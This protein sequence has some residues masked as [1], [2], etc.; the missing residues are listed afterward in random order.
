MTETSRDSTLTLWVQHTMALNDTLTGGRLFFF[1]FFDKIACTLTYCGHLELTAS[2]TLVELLT[3]LRDR[4]DLP[5]NEQ[6]TFYHETIVGGR[7]KVMEI[8][9]NLLLAGVSKLAT[10]SQGEVIF[11]QVSYFTNFFL[12]HSAHSKTNNNVCSNPYYSVLT[13]FEEKKYL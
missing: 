10:G 5:I 3:I 1:K 4:A 13:R 2:I 7:R 11:F 12:S 8:D 6:L 9:P